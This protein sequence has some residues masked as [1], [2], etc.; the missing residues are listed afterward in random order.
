[1]GKPMSWK[2][3]LTILFVVGIFAG[4][5]FMFSQ[6]GYLYLRGRIVQ[7]YDETPEADRRESPAADQFM[8]LAWW[9]S[10]LMDAPTAMEMYKE[11]CGYSAGMEPITKT[12]KLKGLCSPNGKTGWGPLHP[13]APEAYYEYLELM[14]N[15]SSES[16]Q[17]IREEC[18]NYYRLFY[19]WMIQQGPSHKAHPNFNC[20]WGKIRKIMDRTGRVEVPA[21][22]QMNAPQAPKCEEPDIK[23]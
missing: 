3:K 18:F 2:W 7:V 6:S 15:A 19:T 9:R 8:N 23:E 5:I 10:T 21:D 13:R 16:G 12:N 1:M 4:I 20:Y 17:H 14:N 22:I 11:F